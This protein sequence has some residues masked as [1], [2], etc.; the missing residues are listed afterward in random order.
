MVKAGVPVIQAVCRVMG[1]SEKFP[2]AVTTDVLKELGITNNVT[3]K[4]TTKL[5]GLEAGKDFTVLKRACPNQPSLYGFTL[6]AYWGLLL[7]S[8]KY[9]QHVLSLMQALQ[10]IRHQNP[11]LLPAHA[12]RTLVMLERDVA[13][14]LTHGGELAKEII[15]SEQE[16]EQEK[17][18]TAPA[19]APEGTLPALRDMCAFADRALLLDKLVPCYLPKLFQPFKGRISGI[20]QLAAPFGPV[21]SDFMAVDFETSLGRIRDLDFVSLARW[22]RECAAQD[23][24]KL[25]Q[26]Y[27]EYAG[28]MQ[29]FIAIPSRFLLETKT[30]LATLKKATCH[31]DVANYEVQEVI[32]GW[33]R[34]I[35]NLAV[36]EELVQQLLS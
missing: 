31:N 35:R 10:R 8:K 30:F 29:E 27:P 18:D 21:F 5:R 24:P 33:E 1:S 20:F 36:H 13:Q 23:L 32:E 4:L 25:A 17:R 2:V 16:K 19:K 7:Q 14:G 3:R 34:A 26:G 12:T 15:D 22:T 9:Q 11:L 6:N 28:F